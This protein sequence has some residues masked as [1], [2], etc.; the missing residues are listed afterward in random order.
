MGTASGLVVGFL[1]S[2]E[3]DWLDENGVPAAL[4]RV[5]YDAGPLAGDNEDLAIEDM[6]ASSFSSHPE[7]NANHPAFASAGQVGATATPTPTATPRADIV[8]EG[9]AALP[10]GLMPF[11]NARSIVQSLKL[12][13][14]SWHAWASSE[15]RPK[16]IPV[17]PAHAYRGTRG[18][19]SWDDW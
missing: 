14:G 19:V 8:A 12:T 18:W 5:R 7:L 9:I 4:W 3:S 16:S 17:D 2:H 13:R 10:R 15:L 11:D 1:D 6:V